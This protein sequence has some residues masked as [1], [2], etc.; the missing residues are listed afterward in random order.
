MQMLTLHALQV[1]RS[2]LLILKQTTSFASCH[3]DLDARYTVLR[4]TSNKRATHLAQLLLVTKRIHT[5]NA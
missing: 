2:R 4:L 5:Q 3:V 1:L